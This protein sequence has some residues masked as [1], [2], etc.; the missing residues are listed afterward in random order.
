MCDSGHRGLATYEAVVAKK[1]VA[2]PSL[3]ATGRQEPSSGRYQRVT[4]STNMMQYMQFDQLVCL[5]NLPALP[6]MQVQMPGKQGRKICPLSMVVQSKLRLRYC[7]VTENSSMAE[8][9]IRS[10]IAKLAAVTSS[11]PVAAM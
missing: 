3:L 5:L 8:P 6:S 10:H 9:I 11:V 7:R 1:K 4:C 2:E